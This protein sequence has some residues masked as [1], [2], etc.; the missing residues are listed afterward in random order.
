M[1][2]NGV[3]AGVFLWAASAFATTVAPMSLDELALT[4]D[5][6][7]VVECVTAGEVVAEYKVVESWKGPRVGEVV[8]IRTQPNVWGPRMPSEFVGTRVLVA[9]FRDAPARMMSTTSGPG[10][11]VWWRGVR[12]G[13]ELPLFQGRARVLPNGKLVGSFGEAKSL[14]EVRQKTRAF[15]ALEPEQQR[16]MWMHQSLAFK[17]LPEAARARLTQAKTLREALDVAL[18]L[19]V[20]EAND[21]ARHELM[22][23]I[24]DVFPSDLRESAIGSRSTLGPVAMQFREWQTPEPV[25]P[26]EFLRSKLNIDDREFDTAL[27]HL[28]AA[29]CAFVAKWLISQ[30]PFEQDHGYLIGSLVAQGCKTERAQNLALLAR[31]AKDPLVRVAGAVALLGLDK[32]KGEA[33]VRTAAEGTGTAALWAQLTLA[34]RGDKKAAA[35]LVSAVGTAGDGRDWYRESFFL[36]LLVLLSNSAAAS[37]LPQPPHEAKP[38]EVS[39]SLQAWWAK[40]GERLELADPWLAELDALDRD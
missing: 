5:L 30:E 19:D 18:E 2:I 4:S 22:R 15:R 39:K 26:V 28:P 16:L 33:L 23:L 34:R 37:K 24:V 3:V 13:F 9:A 14:D 40:H 38:T 25:P 21:D 29:D 7:G 31:E 35:A 17:R 6:F 12:T 20:P 1:R 27:E 11:P 32:E 36:R 8:R 10:D